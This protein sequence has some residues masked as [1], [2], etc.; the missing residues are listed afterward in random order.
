MARDAH[1]IDRL[2]D[3][4]DRS[5]RRRIASSPRMTAAYQKSATR[6]EPPLGRFGQKHPVLGGAVAAIV[7]G[8]AMCLVFSL[9]V[10]ALAVAGVFSTAI[11]VVVEM[12]MVLLWTV[13]GALFGLSVGR[14]WSRG[15]R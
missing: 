4:V 10:V 9:P 15:E 6:P 12:I 2:V 13:G 14:A 8:G 3:A 5:G 7:W 1:F 11:F